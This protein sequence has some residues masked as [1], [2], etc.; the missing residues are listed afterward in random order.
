MRNIPPARRLAIWGDDLVGYGEPNLKN[1]WWYDLEEVDGVLR[2]PDRA[3]K[4]FI[5]SADKVPEGDEEDE[6]RLK[7]GV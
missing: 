5:L 7:S 3:G 2:V 4:R 6:P 1:K